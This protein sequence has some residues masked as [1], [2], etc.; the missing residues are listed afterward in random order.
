MVGWWISRHGRSLYDAVDEDGIL[1]S[2]FIDGDCVWLYADDAELA[3][4]LRYE[5]VICAICAFMCVLA[6]WLQQV[7]VDQA[8]HIYLVCK[9]VFQVHGGHTFICSAIAPLLRGR[10]L[11]L[12]KC[13]RGSLSMHGGPAE[14]VSHGHRM[15]LRH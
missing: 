7:A 15:V 4:D 5:L 14:M 8:I 1:N 2:R 3:C 13:V 10:L 12:A 11:S 6:F 9:L